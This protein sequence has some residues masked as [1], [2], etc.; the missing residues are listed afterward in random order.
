M[1][2]PFNS[3]CAAVE[4]RLAESSSWAPWPFIAPTAT[5]VGLTTRGPGTRPDEPGRYYPRGVRNFVRVVANNKEARGAADAIVAAHLG[6]RG[7]YLLE[8]G[9]PYSTGLAAA[10]RERGRKLGLEFDGSAV[11]TSDPHRLRA[12]RSEDRRNRRRRR[13]HRRDRGREQATLSFKPSGPPS[14]RVRRFS[15]RMASPRSRPCFGQAPPP[16]ASPSASPSQTPDRLPKRGREFAAAF[17]AAEG[18]PTEPYSLS[19]AQSVD[20]LLA[21]IAHSDGTRASITER[22]TTQPTV[23]GI[24]GSF[25]FDRA[26]DTTAGAVTVYRVERGKA[27]IWDVLQP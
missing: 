25:H 20:T 13:L 22:L 10:I 16:T 8:D 19:A 17:S 11:W 27:V 4:I 3:G 14:A 1:I 21:A 6:V 7:L 5:Y 15:P 24:L 9:S 26:G 18:A 23:G 2:G 12:T